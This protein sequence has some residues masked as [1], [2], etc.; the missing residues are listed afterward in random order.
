MNS[1]ITSDV[2]ISCAVADGG[3]QILVNKF[4]NQFTLVNHV[5]ACFFSVLNMLVTI[6]LNS[7]TFATFWSSPKMRKST[8]LF[9]VMILS[10]HDA[11][12]GLASNSVFTVRLASEV[13][14]T[15]ECGIVFAQPVSTMV[16]TVTSL[17][18]VTAI[19]IERYI[20]V[21]H[22]MYHHSKLKKRTL[23][24]FIMLFWIATGIALALSFIYDYIILVRF[25]TVM[26]SLII[27]FTMFAY[28]RIGIEVIASERKRENL[29]PSSGNDQ[30]QGRKKHANFLK[31]I[32]LAKSCFMIV[33]CYVLCSTPVIVF[34]EI[35]RKS[36][37]D[38]Y[39]IIAI[40]WCVNFVL[41][42]SSLNSVIFFWR[43]R[44]LRKESICLLKKMNIF[45]KIIDS[46]KY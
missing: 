3:R 40:A 33:I 45:N 17:V 42:N 18:T 12:G 2:L 31:E 39:L 29:S 44:E 37:P 11:V 20:G 10:G 32:K 15:V 38:S 22:P 35:L 24:K 27:L 13:F 16:M 19:N 25:A 9:L 14:G 6:I 5:A 43:S 8:S 46:C 23:F 26:C 28:T 30:C 41:L 21:I 4:P 34:M 1:S 7:L 36:L